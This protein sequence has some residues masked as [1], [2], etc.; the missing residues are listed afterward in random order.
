MP[1]RKKAR[2]KL[3]KEKRAER[4]KS[5]WKKQKYKDMA[6]KG[7]LGQRELDLYKHMYSSIKDGMESFA[8]PDYNPT[9]QDYISLKKM[10]SSLDSK[11]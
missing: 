6:D 2:E 4:N 5:N 11:L 3:L 10:Y 8:H 7:I 1:S 9:R